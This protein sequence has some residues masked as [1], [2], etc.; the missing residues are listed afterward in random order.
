MRW[1]AFTA[2]CLARLRA[3][4]FTSLADSTVVADARV[5]L[6]QIGYDMWSITIF[7]PSGA[8]NFNVPAEAVLTCTQA[9]VH[10]RSPHALVRQR[11]PWL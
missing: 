9:E 6:A 3:T 10:D 1:L 4:G 7:T 11:S 2:D 8:L 5:H